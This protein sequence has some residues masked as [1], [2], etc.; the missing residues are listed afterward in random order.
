VEI[1]PAA[2]KALA[3]YRQNQQLSAEDSQTL[4]AEFAEITAAADKMIATL[5]QTDPALWHEIEFWVKSFKALGNAGTAAVKLASG[6]GGDATGQMELFS[7]IANNKALQQ[8]F[9]DAQKQRHFE[10]TFA[11]DKQWAKGCKVSTLVLTPLVDELFN[12]EWTKAAEKMG[13]KLAADNAAY[14]AFSNVE[15]MQ[16]LQAERDGKYVNL[17]R[18]LEVVKLQPNDHLGLALP[19][20][21]FGNYIHIKLDNAAAADACK[22]EVS[23][24][25]ADWKP[26]NARKGGGELQNPLN[27]ND[28]I[29]FFRLVNSSEKPIEFRIEKF[30]FDVP[31]GA[32][33]N[34]VAA[35][36][37]GDPTSFY[38]IDQPQTLTG[39]KD[40]KK[41]IVLSDAP[42][43]A[44][45][46]NGNQVTITPPAGGK[47]RI[48]EVLWQ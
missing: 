32:A 7:V 45:Q 2:D 24:N 29:R 14:Q 44:I 48:F 16:N 10:E 46:Q 25:R 15:S 26:F 40:A 6:N 27:V 4:L 35:T 31:D 19:E 42:A 9:Y 22:V 43:S 8:D 37:D 3:H 1:K 11:S 18:I 39:P 28:K 30:K 34:P 20:G 33:A 41:A 23:T 36:Q 47:V 17:A 38:T 13:G 12:A 5:P 21:V